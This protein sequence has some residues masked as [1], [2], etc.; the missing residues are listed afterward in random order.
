[1][2]QI[3]RGSLLEATMT[4]DLMANHDLLKLIIMIGL[5]LY[6]CQKIYSSIGKLQDMRMDSTE[7][8]REQIIFGIEFL[9]TNHQN[10]AE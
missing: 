1:M 6:L 10:P 7:T 5:G 9:C 4:G 3:A 8:G 2:S